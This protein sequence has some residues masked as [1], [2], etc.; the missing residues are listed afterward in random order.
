MTK[1]NPSNAQNLTFKDSVEPAMGITSAKEAQEYKQDYI[2]YI[3]KILVRKGVL[4][5][6]N[7]NTAE[8]IVNRNLGYH[9]HFHSKEAIDRVKKL[10]GVDFVWDV[11][12]LGDKPTQK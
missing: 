4:I 5:D 1:F 9:S 11:K 2:L 12:K 8:Q 3:K 10:F 6:T 7:G